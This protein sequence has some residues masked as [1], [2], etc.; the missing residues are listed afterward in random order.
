VDAPGARGRY[1]DPGGIADMVRVALVVN[2]I[3][4]LLVTVFT[5]QYLFALD[6]VSS[7]ALGGLGDIQSAANRLH[8]GDGI[9]FW[10]WFLCGVP[11][12][13]WTHRT[14]SNLEPLGAT[15]LRF[16]P[17]WAI[18]GWLVPPFALWRP[19][20]IVN[21]AWRAS[22]RTLPANAAREEW[23]AR[24]T[25]FVMTAWWVLWVVGA[26]AERFSL[27]F[28]NSSVESARTTLAIRVGG[29][30]CLAA[31]A[32]LAVWVVGALTRRQQERARVLGM[33]AGFEGAAV[34]LGPSPE[35]PASA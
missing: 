22:D 17:G 23:A 16:R 5:I 20:Q 34:A 9:T 35:R 3:V 27:N 18:G 31:A 10:A 33:A 8:V 7:G 1:E 2:A 29:G 15:R 19:K 26:L 14:Y 12:I 4:S 21:D 25:P 13:V 6:G 30:V 24:S 28:A 11:F 32:L